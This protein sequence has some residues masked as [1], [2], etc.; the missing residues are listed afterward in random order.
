MQK[1]DNDLCAHQILIYLIVAQEQSMRLVSETL[2]TILFF[3]G[4]API[5]VSHTDETTM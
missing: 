4:L 5:E 1:V 3:F 2:W